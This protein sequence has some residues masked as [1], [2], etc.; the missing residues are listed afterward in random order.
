MGGSL[1]ARKHHLGEEFVTKTGKKIKIIEYRSISDIDVQFEDGAIARGKTYGNIRKGEVGHPE[2]S[3]WKIKG[4]AKHEGETVMANNGHKMTI[5]AYRTYEDCDVE[6]DTGACVTGVS[7]RNFRKGLV[8]LK[9]KPQKKWIAGYH[10]DE[11]GVSKEGHKI[12]ILNY[13]GSENID[14][15]FE[16]GT[17]VKGKTYGQFTGKRIVYPKEK[18]NGRT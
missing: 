11:E 6:F 15:I 9:K 8:S 18:T 5:I 1:E 4:K 13:Y 10:Q 3:G 14:V 12:R 17:I 7:Y 2:E 16:D